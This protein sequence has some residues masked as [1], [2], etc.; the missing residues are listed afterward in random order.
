MKAFRRLAVLA[1]LLCTALLF[2]SGVP[3]EARI[4]HG[5][6]CRDDG[7]KV[8]CLYSG[9]SWNYY[10]QSDLI[11]RRT[12]CRNMPMYNFG[13]GSGN[14]VY[15]GSVRNRTPCYLALQYRGSAGRWKCGEIMVP[16]SDDNRLG[17]LPPGGGVGT[18]YQKTDRIDFR[19][20]HG[21]CRP[22]E[23]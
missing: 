22:N 18:G 14:R 9:E 7:S 23:F 20:V 13:P 5:S 19:A 3:A 11:P 4:I 16:H 1:A 10:K 15:V 21:G 17:D 2:G 6:G 8:V 12:S